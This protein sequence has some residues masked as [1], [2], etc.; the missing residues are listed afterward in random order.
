MNNLV[1]MDNK[2]QLKILWEKEKP[3]FVLDHSKNEYG[4]IHINI[5]YD[6]KLSKERKKIEKNTNPLYQNII[7]LFFYGISHSHFSRVF[8]KTSKF[9]KNFL[10]F[11]GINNENDT[12]QKYH[13][14]KFLKQD[15]FI[16][17]TLGNN[18]PMF[19]GKPFYSKKDIKEVNV[20]VVKKEKEGK[21]DLFNTIKIIIK[22]QIFYYK[23]N[24]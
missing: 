17:F 2:E 20:L 10:K 21:A 23:I 13:G 3:E 11:E 6:E 7:F 15:S 22:K 8:E 18:I 24:K 1:D 16:E 14:C 5:N 9:L 4:D 19:Y 12:S